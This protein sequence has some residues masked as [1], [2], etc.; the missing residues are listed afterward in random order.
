MDFYEVKHK[1]RDVAITIS[2]TRY[3]DIIINV[4]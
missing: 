1:N 3:N 2:E 4:L